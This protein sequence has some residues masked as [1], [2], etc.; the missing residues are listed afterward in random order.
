M[1]EHR[2][3]LLGS[4]ISKVVTLLILALLAV[5]VYFVWEYLSREA[6]HR[7]EIRKLQQIVERLTSERRVAQVV[8]R[9]RK[10]DAE[11]NVT[12]SLDFHQWDREGKHLPPVSATVPGNEVFFEA[13]VIKFDREYVEQG[14]AL[15]GKTIVLF[16]R[17]FGS[18]QKPEDGVKIDPDATD[19]I[20]SIYRVDENA[21]EFE[22]NLWKRFWYYAEHPTEAAKLGVRVVQ[23]EA[24]G[25]PLTSPVYEITCEASG[26]PNLIP[27]LP[28][29][30]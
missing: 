3:S 6:R 18:A 21:S 12:T 2:R 22:V 20:P 17:I 19:G 29:T 4:L 11:G 26:G 27:M 16:R 23:L 1:S 30:P 15:R 14:D 9:D 13:M 28:K 5:G 7:E 8:V 24:V 25:N 10:T